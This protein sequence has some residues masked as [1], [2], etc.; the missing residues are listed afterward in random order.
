MK[1]QRSPVA[2][3]LTLLG[4][5]DY[6]V[7]ELMRKLEGK[8]YQRDEIDAAVTRLREWKYL[9]DERYLRRL[10]EKYRKDKKSRSYIRGRLS[11]AGLEPEMIEEGLATIYPPEQE[12][13]IVRFWWEK[14][15]TA[16][17]GSPQE[18]KE[19][20]RWARRLYA[21]GFPAEAIRPYLD[22]NNES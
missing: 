18:K 13:E 5:R 12:K 22:R 10:I 15:F 8:G 16:S 4:R 2:Y 1:P 14:C 7:R 20:I 11:L 21:A 6:S 3:S 19:V 17:G 9:D